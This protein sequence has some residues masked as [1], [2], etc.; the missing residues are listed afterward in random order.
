MEK[1][2][3]STLPQ[4]TDYQKSILR[5]GQPN[6]KTPPFSFPFS[7][8]STLLLT[9]HIYSSSF[10]GNVNTITDLVLT[11]PQDLAKRCRISTS[12]I[13]Q[14]I[15]VVCN[16]QGDMKFKFKTLDELKNEDEEIV[17]SIGD[18]V[19]DEVLNGGLRT[20]MVWEFVGERYV[21]YIQVIYLLFC[22]LSLSLTPS[23]KNVP[24]KTKLNIISVLQEK[25]KSH[26]NL[27][28][29]FNFPNLK[30]EQKVQHVI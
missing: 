22:L 15:H 14:L 25:L 16:N 27:H 2:L 18:K 10:L 28:F 4:L 11:P 1:V 29:M 23:K 21:I 6:T 19:L 12:E 9:S 17:F 30:V 3:L 8:T 20:G 7:S 13:V 26:Y 5:K 24:L